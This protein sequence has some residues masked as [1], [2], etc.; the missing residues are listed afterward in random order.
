MKKIN[1]LFLILTINFYVF[2]QNDSLTIDYYTYNYQ[3]NKGKNFND[4][5]NNFL[6]KNVTFTGVI[7][8]Q[9]F[10]KYQGYGA[11]YLMSKNF[12]T[13]K[14]GE[15]IKSYIIFYTSDNV[16]GN[17][18][19][20]NLKDT[21]ITIEFY[22]N[23]LGYSID[24]IV[25]R[26]GDVDFGSGYIQKR[27]KFYLEKFYG[28]ENGKYQTSFRQVR[29]VEGLKDG[30][31]VDYKK[32]DFNIDSTDSSEFNISTFY[33]KG[34][35]VDVFSKDALFLDMNGKLIS[36]EEYLNFLKIDDDLYPKHYGLDL[37][38]EERF[39]IKKMP[40]IFYLIGNYDA[41]PKSSHKELDKWLK[42]EVEKAKKKNSK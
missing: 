5:I 1:L 32:Y 13:C 16:R 19:F 42:K 41:I 14:M 6:K 21:T 36:K 7:C 29:R 11:E 25:C 37:T 40:I 22:P 18:V 2:S 26:K 9:T 39:L 24:T 12:T 10:V 35:L 3:Q 38:Y 23:T 28:F 33:E 31:Q 17:T 20:S 15:K 34:K 4:T 8:L 30:L 27:E